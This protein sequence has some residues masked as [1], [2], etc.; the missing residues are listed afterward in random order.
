MIGEHAD[1]VVGKA[2]DAAIDALL[3]E[4][5]TPL[6]LEGTLAVQREFESRGAEIDAARRQHVE[7]TRYEAE[8]ARR[9]YMSVDPDNRLVA[10]TLEAEWND[11]LRIHSDG[12]TEYDRRAQE[13]AATLDEQSLRRIRKLAEQFPRVWNDPRAPSAER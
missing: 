8:L 3:I 9:R 7:R 1:L 5:I 12:A 6:N 4:L 11:K 10:S 2:V 13:Q